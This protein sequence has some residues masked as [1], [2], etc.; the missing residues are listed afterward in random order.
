[1]STP[2]SRKAKIQAATPKQGPNRIVIATVVAVV[3]IIAVVAGT[4]VANRSSDAAATAGGS[5]LPRGAAAMGAGLT[6]ELGTATSG[7]VV[8]VYEDFQC[9]VCGQ[10]EKFYGDA[11]RSLE[12]SGKAQVRFH[13]LTFLDGNLRND[14][15]ARAANA[16]M[17]AA[18]AGRFSAFHQQVYGHMPAKEGQGYTDAQLEGFAQAAGVTGPALTTWQKC[19]K[20]KAH[21]Q[22]VESVQTQS[23]KDGVRGTPTVRVNGKDFSFATVSPEDF[24]AKVLE[25]AK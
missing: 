6:S 18:D 7:P 21:N 15:S 5:A 14:S 13:V 2:A 3:A 24:A 12:R 20:D 25:A 19:V 10:F 22:Y 8:D 11:V 16:A 9:P 23:D 1:M 17:C 4:V